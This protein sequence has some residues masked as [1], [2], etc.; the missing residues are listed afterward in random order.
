MEPVK[1]YSLPKL[2]YEYSAL[3]PFIS[4]EQLKLHHLKHHQA[5]VNGANAILEKMSDPEKFLD[6]LR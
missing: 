3:A 5:Y 1:L 6:D 4:E 2:S